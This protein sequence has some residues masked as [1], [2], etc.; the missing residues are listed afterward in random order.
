M[1]H[2]PEQG[3]IYKNY[4]E[5]FCIE[6]LSPLSHLFTYSVIYLHQ[7]GLMNIYFILWFLI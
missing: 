2:L 6:D 5:F 1:F 4:L 3:S 7:Y